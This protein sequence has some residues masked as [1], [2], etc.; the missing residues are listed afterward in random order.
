MT[1]ILSLAPLLER[2]FTQRL[3]HQRRVS[4]LWRGDLDENEFSL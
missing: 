1:S 3:M 4:P 2:F